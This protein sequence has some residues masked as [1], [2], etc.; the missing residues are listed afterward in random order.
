MTIS[1]IHPCRPVT[2][3]PRGNSSGGLNTH[4]N[5]TNI[6]MSNA[7]MASRMERTPD[8]NWLELVKQLAPVV[9]GAIPQIPKPLI[10]DI[11]DGIHE[12]EGL[13][14]ATGAEKKAHAL[15]LVGDAITGVNAAK[16]HTV[17]DP[18]VVTDVVGQGIDT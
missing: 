6:S 5:R 2:A 9:L 14:K 18:H 13:T 10:P 7:D 4:A 15:G 3:S 12:A 16:G 8:M 17:I 11:V 1:S